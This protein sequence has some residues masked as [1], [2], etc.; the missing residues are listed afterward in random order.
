MYFNLYQIMA[1]S[2]YHK[3]SGNSLYAAVWILTL[4]ASTAYQIWMIYLILNI[5]I[6]EARDTLNTFEAGLGKPIL[7]KKYG[8]HCVV[9][10]SSRPDDPFHNVRHEMDWH[11][12]SHLIGYWTKTLI[13]RDVAFAMVNS[14]LFEILEYT[15]VDHIPSFSEC[16]YDTL[17]MDITLANTLGIVLA[18]KTVKWFSL[19][20]YE[21]KYNY[22]LSKWIRINILLLVFLFG[23]LNTFYLYQILYIPE[24]HYLVI[25]RCVLYLS[26]SFVA[27]RE[28]YVHFDK[29][30]DFFTVGIHCYIG[31]IFPVSEIILIGKW[32][33]ERLTTAIPQDMVCFWTVFI[34]LM[35][36]WTAWNFG[37][38]VRKE[39]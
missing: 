8:Q 17:F 32:D 39:K 24:F 37:F 38:G 27:T 15:L 31:M 13:Y 14:I 7:Y 20:R 19:Q 2:K 12:L 34:I 22:S 3:P 26:L 23:E 21:W 4:I 5:D 25:I 35:L 10:N 29:D 28:L 33:Y 6:T 16:W 11:I 30:D 9:Y 36:T 1:V 18:M